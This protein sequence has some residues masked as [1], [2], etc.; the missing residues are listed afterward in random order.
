MRTKLSRLT[1]AKLA[2]S[3][4]SK[5][6]GVK[7][8]SCP[9]CGTAVE[10][11]ADCYCCSGCEVA[12]GLIREAGLERYYEER[13]KL[14][15]RSRVLED[16]WDA[17]PFETDQA[18]MAA[19]RLMIDGLRCAS[20]VWV[21]EHLLQNTPG[22]IAA[23]VSYATGRCSIRWDPHRTGL[24][25]IAGL[26]A[27]LGYRPRLLGEEAQVDRDLL[28]RLGVAAFAAANI[29]MM[30]AALYAGW[31]SSMDPRFVVLFQW[32]SLALATPV[33]LWCAVPFY[34][35]A[36]TGVRNGVLHM[37]VPIALGVIVLYVQGVVATIGSGHAYVDSLAMLVALLLAGRMLESRGRRRAAEAALSL[38]ASVPTSA[39]RATASGVETVRADVLRPGDVI[40]VGAGEEL[41]A[42]GTVSA[43]SGR[44]RMALI[45]G[46]SEPVE[47]GP[48]AE[49]VAGS[50][51]LD[52]AVAV[53]VSAVGRDTVLQQMAEQL[54]TA[55]DRGARPTSSDRIAPWFTAGTLIV[56]AATFT[57]WTFV[58]GLGTA[59]PRAVAVL[60]VA[61]PCALALSRPL[62]AAA[63]LG[64]AARR[65]LLFRSADSLLDLMAVDTVGLD[66]TGTVT[67]GAL[68]VL[69]AEDESLRVAA[70]LERYSNHPIARAI[71]DEAG[72]RAIPLPRG[73]D[74][75]ETPG[76]GISGRVSGRLWRLRAGGAGQVLLLD[77]D[78]HSAVIELGDAIRPD[79]A[80]AIARLVELG[81]EITLLTG[82]HERVGQRIGRE[83]GLNTVV[84]R[85]DPAGKAEWVRSKQSEGHR[86]LFGGDGIN[87][88]PALAQADV[89]V[90]MGSGAASSVLVADGVISA[91]SLG[92]IP[93]GFVAALACARAIRLNQMRSIA[94][95]VLAVSAAALGFVNPLVAAVLMPLSSAMVIWGSARVEGVVRRQVQ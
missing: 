15:P 92:P 89:G 17:V 55:A 82:D 7:T 5:N 84:A 86:V 69:R 62:A 88:G 85:I 40:D 60:V 58:A 66:K 23:T 1:K 41:A 32:G 79:S 53:T 25:D 73:T 51:L 77:D 28:L 13:S 59:L 74:I 26:I 42:D 22:V 31:W 70:G 65:G 2:S 49:V 20:C 94:Y 90:A 61:C 34:A 46:E 56:A 30:S 39:R 21:T 16:G 93:T 29:M 38:A 95:N 12:A 14:A 63:G 76:V 87:D 44:V 50:V 80:R 27:T 9:H 71:V 48:G 36:L 67:K 43:G 54:R 8:G 11:P 83:I 19:A 33:A 52:G 72:R 47:I 37:D 10:G 18:G 75:V 57:T 4:S 45:T 6:E 68:T 35:G 64:A 24:A 81:L 3:S 78:G 91:A